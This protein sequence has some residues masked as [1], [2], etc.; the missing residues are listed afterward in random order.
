[1]AI[2]LFF[3]LVGVWRKSQSHWVVAFALAF[4]LMVLMFMQSLKN[5]YEATLVWPLFLLMSLFSF[6]QSSSW[7]KKT[8]KYAAVPTLIILQ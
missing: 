7:A 3:G 2:G 6:S 5:F 8:L 4:C 1:M